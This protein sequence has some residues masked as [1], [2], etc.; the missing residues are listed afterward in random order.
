MSRYDLTDFEWRLIKPLLPNTRR[1][2]ALARLSLAT[3]LAE[4]SGALR[5]Y[6]AAEGRS[7]TPVTI[8]LICSLQAQPKRRAIRFTE[9]LTGYASLARLG[10]LVHRHLVRDAAQGHA[11]ARWLQPDG[12]EQGPGIGILHH[13]FRYHDRA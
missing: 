10:Y 9:H 3:R 2:D 4:F 6:L 1:P 11:S 12:L 7:P 13:R 8:L 5:K